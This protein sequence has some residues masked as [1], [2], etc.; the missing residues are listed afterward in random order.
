MVTGGD[1]GTTSCCPWCRCRCS[2]GTGA[3][4]GVEQVQSGH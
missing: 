2:A 1:R 4:A 3:G